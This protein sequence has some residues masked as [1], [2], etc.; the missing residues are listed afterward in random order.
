[1]G[2]KK[3]AFVCWFVWSGIGMM[4]QYSWSTSVCVRQKIYVMF[5]TLTFA[6]ITYGKQRLLSFSKF[7]ANVKN[8]FWNNYFK[9]VK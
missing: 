7:L 6:T 8:L 9:V 3:A 4:I 5:A 2:E 1:M